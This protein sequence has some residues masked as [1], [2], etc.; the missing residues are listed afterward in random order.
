[1][2]PRTFSPLHIAQWHRNELTAIPIPVGIESGG[3]ELN[4]PLVNLP[5]PSHRASRIGWGRRS[6]GQVNSETDCQY[7]FVLPTWR[8]VI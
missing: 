7:L 4:Q 8:I 6:G 5:R 3:R 1:M 2:N